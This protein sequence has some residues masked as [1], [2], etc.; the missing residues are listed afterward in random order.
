M[1]NK[2]IENLDN[3]EVITLEY[4]GINFWGIALFKVPGKNSYFG[5]SELYNNDNDVLKNVTIDDLYYFGQ[6]PEDDPMGV[7]TLG[8]DKVLQ[9]GGKAVIFKLEESE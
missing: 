7:P 8:K 4:F 9:F 5:T 3:P 2:K 1:M 6:N